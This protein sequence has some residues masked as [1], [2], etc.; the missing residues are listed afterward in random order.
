MWI[1]LNWVGASN[2]A[3]IIKLGSTFEKE[4]ARGGEGTHILWRMAKDLIQR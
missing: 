4:Q 3:G 1:F 2:L